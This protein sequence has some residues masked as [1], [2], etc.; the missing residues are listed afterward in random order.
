VI[1]AEAAEPLIVTSADG[2]PVAC[3]RTG[4]G[5]P[6]VLVH[7]TGE[8]HRRWRLVAARLGRRF[9]VY[10]VDRRGR[11]ASGDAAPYSLAAEAADIA[12]VV[13]HLARATGG[14]VSVLA[15]SYGAICAVEA[16][17]LATGL[18]GLVLYEPP[19]PVP[20]SAD[21]SGLAARLRRL[22]ADGQ[23]D[24]AVT[25]FLVLAAGL[26]PEQVFALRTGNGHRTAERAALASTLAREIEATQG[27]VLRPGAFAA[28]AAPVLLLVG[29]RSPA[30]MRAAVDM[31]A[32]ALPRSRV[33]VL[34]GQ[35]HCAMDT[36]PR[37]FLDT[38]LGFFEE[39]MAA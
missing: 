2:V 32:A 12:A 20:G 19:I 36:A 18:A 30:T 24:R 6:L 16:A 11:G 35:S 21:F 39:A 1:A 22:V 15:H 3:W 29:Q 13:D 14:A 31:L 5:P 23:A 17:R 4:T 38:V 33:T 9:A 7:G 26:P 25:D 10:A 28:L 34:E 27:Y 8:D 37:A